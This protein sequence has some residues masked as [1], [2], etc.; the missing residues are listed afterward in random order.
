MRVGGGDA[1][2]S[3][4]WLCPVL[5]WLVVPSFSM[6]GDAHL[7]HGWRCPT[8]PTGGDDDAQPSSGWRWPASS[9]VVMPLLPLRTAA[10]ENKHFCRHQRL[11]WSSSLQRDGQQ[12]ACSIA[13]SASRP[14]LHEAEKNIWEFVGPCI[15]SFPIPIWSHWSLAWDPIVCIDVASAKL[16]AFSGVKIYWWVSTLRCY[17]ATKSS[18]QK[19]PFLHIAKWALPVSPLLCVDPRVVL[20]FHTT[21][22]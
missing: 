18:L 1:S 14:R 22:D 3:H 6:V 9:W 4:R 19:D 21:K 13:T 20:S 11:V 2:V 10:S 8:L 5:S 7:A 16:S 12:M 17:F 15:N